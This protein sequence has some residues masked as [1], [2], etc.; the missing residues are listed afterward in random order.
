MGFLKVNFN[1][2]ESKL[3][4]NIRLTYRSKY[5][6]YDSNNNSYLDSYDEFVNG[7]LITD[8]AVNKKINEYSKISIGINNLFDFKDIENITNISGR[9]YYS[10]INFYL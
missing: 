10:K 9:I 1:N 6:L 7:Y 3:N 5:G 4:A 8:L 2:L